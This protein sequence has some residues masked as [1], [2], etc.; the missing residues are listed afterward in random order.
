MPNKKT[1]FTQLIEHKSLSLKF[2]DSAKFFDC[3][4]KEDPSL[5]EKLE[6][7]NV[8]AKLHVSLANRLDTTVNSLNISKREFIQ[9]ALIEA[10]DRADEIMSEVDITEFL[11]EEN[12]FNDDGSKK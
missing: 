1:I 3:A 12:G 6:L 7:K 9:Y 8:C 4:I 10:L 11:R 2:D 5:E